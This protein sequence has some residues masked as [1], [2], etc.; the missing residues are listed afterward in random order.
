M[1]ASTWDA[2]APADNSWKVDSGGNDSN[3]EDDGGASLPAN[4]EF[5][6]ANTSMHAAGNDGCRICGADSHFARDCPDKPEGGGGG[7][8]GGGCFNCGEEGH[9]KADCPNPRVER[10]FTG[11]CRVC[12][13]EG[14]RAAD[15]PSRPPQ[16]CRACGVEGHNAAECEANRM[17]GLFAQLNVQ[18]KSVEESWANI[19]TADKQKDV[20]E[21]KK[22]IFAY[23]KS[24]PDLTLEELEKSFR[25]GDMNI[26]LIA[27]EQEVPGSYTIVNFQ[28]KKDLKYVVS[29]QLAAKP[30]RAKFAEGW[31]SS[32]EE[33]MTRLAEA[34]FVMD[35]FVKKCSNCS[36]F[37][38]GSKDCEQEKQD[39]AR[40]AITCA[41]CN[42]DGH[43]ARDCTEPRKSGNKG[44]KNCGS[45]EHLVKECPEP[46]MDLEC[47]LC[48]KNGHM[49]RECPDKP[50]E[51]CRNCGEEGHRKN[52]C[53]NERRFQ[54]RNC[55]EW[56]HTGR[57]C[58]EPRNMAKVQ[59]RNCDEMGHTSKECPQPTDW[60]RVECSKCKQKGHSYKR[61]TNPAAEEADEFGGDANGDGGW[62][63]GAGGFGGAAAASSGGDGGWE[64]NASAPVASSG[65]GW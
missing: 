9:N 39:G 58:P 36:E 2:P 48:G 23:A 13:Q 4:G 54:C 47:N 42:E 17:L 12:D 1:G 11:T 5:S 61:C 31:P 19:E 6:A 52:D 26:H 37:G 30:K 43:R 20:E 62:E 53:T 46:R 64:D 3:W 56:G 25:D 57:E 14:H 33:N 10:E 29:F 45:E 21:I 55:D 28:G 7:G 22:G 40:V 27:K 8:H 51:V 38:H 32:P 41:N 35:S 44:C 15:C 49:S 50:P 34:G 18:D 60:S 59:C 63:D 65:G 24:F 16:K